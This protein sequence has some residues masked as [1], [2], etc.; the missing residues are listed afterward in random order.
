MKRSLICFLLLFCAPLLASAEVPAAVV[1]AASKLVPGVTW[2][3]ESIV[4]GNFSCQGRVERAILGTTKSEIVVAVFLG[5]LSKPPK[6]LRYSAKTRDPSTS[7]LE[8]ED[9]D[10]DPKE[11]E[12]EVGYIPDGLRPSKTCKGL[13]L[14]D[15]KIDSAHIYWNHNAKQFNDWVL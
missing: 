13:N 15:G 5:G 7:E 3:G 8:I 10:F 6:V 12:S 9:G 2:K 1:A 4:V 14:S 11:F